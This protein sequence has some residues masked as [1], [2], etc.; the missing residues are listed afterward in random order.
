MKSHLTF[1]TTAGMLVGLAG[2]ASTPPPTVQIGPDAEVTAD[3][4]VKVD[5]SVMQLAYVQPDLDLQPYTKLMLDD[6]V[7][8]Y[9]KDPEGRRRNS[10]GGVGDA[11]FALSPSQMEVL[12]SLFQEA[13]VK[14]WTKDDGWEIVDAPGPD[15]MRISA[16][17]IDLVVKSPTQNTA[18]RQ[19]NFASSYAEVTAVLELHDSES[20]EILARVA[21]RGDPASGGTDLSSVS[22]AF[23]RGDL[24]RM[25]EYWTGLL[26]QRLDE[27][28]EVGLP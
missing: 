4:L 10:P 27:V 17:L 24:T 9:K 2:C 6:I 20:E 26:R 3:G 5:N 7:V 11:N 23:V 14:E 19:Q 1:V 18:G 13:L 22:S 28:R 15:V 21:E 8:A 25:F 12:K 16:Y